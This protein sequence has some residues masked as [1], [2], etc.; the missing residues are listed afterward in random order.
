MSLSTI[1]GY[2]A[3]VRSPYDPA[4]RFPAGS[5]DGKV[6]IVTGGHGGIG[7]STTKF[8]VEGGA[9]VIIASRTGKKVDEAIEELVRNKPQDVGIRNRLTWV[10]L[11]LNSLKQVNESAEE[12]LSK[13]E[14]LDGIVCNAGIM[15]FPHELTQDGIEQQFQVNHLG[16]FLFVTKLLPLLEK[17]FDVT[18]HPGRVVNLSSFAHN[19]ISLYPF[20]SLS[21]DSKAAINRTYGSKWMRYS[22]AK[23]SNIYFAKE[24]NRRIT[25]GKVRALAV[26][27][28]F[29][30]SNLYDENPVPDFV[31]KIFIDIDEG[32]YSSVYA[33]ADSDIETKNLWG[34]YLVPFNTPIEARR[35]NDAAKAREL[36]DLSEALIREALAK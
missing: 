17:T 16:H 24:L 29:V 35:A 1:T 28:G 15:A 22:V 23:L 14:R 13:E 6:F 26:H 8:L 30:K 9:R 25:S 5:L 3:N 33:V 2:K 34:A 19:F 18:G 31:K 32:A 10:K 36:W 12:I 27:P 20:A 11:D 4:T 7:L 21:F